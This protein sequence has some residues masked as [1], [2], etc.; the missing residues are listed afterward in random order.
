M[1]GNLEPE[2]RV[3]SMDRPD[4]FLGLLAEKMQQL[5]MT[6]DVPLVV[7][8]AGGQIYEI[9][10]DGSRWKPQ[11]GTVKYNRDAFIVIKRAEKPIIGSV[12]PND[13]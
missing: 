12:A 3:M 6:N 1:L 10:G 13:K 11:K 7:E 2:E 8:I 9:E 4:D 5:N